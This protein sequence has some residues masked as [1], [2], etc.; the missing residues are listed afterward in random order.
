MQSANWCVL[1]NTK[2][3]KTFECNSSIFVHLW[4]ATLEMG[5]NCKLVNAKDTFVGAML[6]VEYGI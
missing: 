2:K 5:S 6:T 4:L 1:P 3:K